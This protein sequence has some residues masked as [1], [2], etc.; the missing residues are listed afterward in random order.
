MIMV[1]SVKYDE[2]A[3][4]LYVQISSKKPFLT[5]E[6]NERLAVDIT[7]SNIPVG[8]EIL[9]AS[10][11]VSELFGKHVS[12]EKVASM[13]CR[14]SSS[15]QL[16]LDFELAGAGRQHARVAIPTVYESPIVSAA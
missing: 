14:V 3:D 5:F 8:V 1:A 2:E 10:R 9:E 16:Y 7:Q 11:F 15:D 12:K 6:V 13:L 4:S